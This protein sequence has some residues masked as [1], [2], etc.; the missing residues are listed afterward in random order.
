MQRP[1]H[2]LDQEKLTPLLR[3]TCHD[4]IADAV[5]ELGRLEEIGRFR[6][7]SRCITIKW[8]LERGTSGAP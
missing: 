2:Q 4:S 5:T 6:Q 8:Q 7:A 1:T 3:L